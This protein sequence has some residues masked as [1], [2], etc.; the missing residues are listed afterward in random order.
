[1]DP[2][3]LW[4]DYLVANSASGRTYRVALRGWEPGDSFCTCP[5]FRKNT[6]GLC[7]HVLAVQQRRARRK[8]APAAQRRPYRPKSVAVHLRYGDSVE[9][10]VIVPEKLDERAVQIIKPVKR[11][12]GQRCA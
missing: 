8:F 1:M 9:L 6:L 10:R 5:D 7:K 12:R 4:A 11:W 3:A 2:K